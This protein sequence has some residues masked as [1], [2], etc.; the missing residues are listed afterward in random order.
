[1][2]N[3]MKLVG[4][5]L[6]GLS[7]HGCAAYKPVPEGYTGPVAVVADSGM[8]VD[9][10]KSIIFALMDVDGQGI[11]NSFRASAGA[12]HGRGFA[13]TTQF[14]GRP[15]PASKAMKVRLKGSHITG[16]PI[17]AIAS[18]IAGTFFSVEGVVDFTPMSGGNY[19]VRG[20]LKKGGSS[21]WI[22]DRATGLPVTE[23]IIEK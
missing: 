5:L 1:M 16:A 10:T 3:V 7:L 18:Q 20:E 6:F 4:G 23:K 15:V 11:D 21:V 19:V 8:P 13:L 17:H 2:I 22:E 12:S 14:V 9:G